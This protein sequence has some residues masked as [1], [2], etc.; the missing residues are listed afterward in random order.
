MVKKFSQNF[1]V[2]HGCGNC[3]HDGTNKILNKYRKCISPTYRSFWKNVNHVH[4]KVQTGAQLK[5][6]STVTEDYIR[7]YFSF[8]S[9]INKKKEYLSSDYDSTD[10]E[11]T[12]NESINKE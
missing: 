4:N 12:D 1:V 5:L 3:Y 2:Y 6:K 8:L 11:S 9:A 10:D 7:R